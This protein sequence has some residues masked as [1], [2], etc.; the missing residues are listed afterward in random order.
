MAETNAARHSEKHE[1]GGISA[2]TVI[3]VAVAFL[4]FTAVS[5]VPLYYY[6]T[7]STSAVPPPRPRPFAK[8][9]LEA[10]PLMDLQTL[11]EKQ[12]SQ[13]KGYA[14]ADTSRQIAR[15]PIERAMQMLAARG[16]GAYGPVTAGSA[17]S[18][19][20][21]PAKP[22]DAS[23][24]APPAQSSGTPAQPAPPATEGHP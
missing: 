18:D 12:R 7:W 3:S 20:P 21:A 11:Q 1:P 9:A 4:L 10:A 16:T 5:L 6:Y 8:P 22:A 17:P 23:P 13:L 24:A 14:W 19:T 2:R 15:I